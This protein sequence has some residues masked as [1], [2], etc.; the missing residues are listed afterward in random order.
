MLEANTAYGMCMHAA[1]CSPVCALAFLG[2]VCAPFVYW[3]GRPLTCARGP[4]CAAPGSCGAR[5]DP[6]SPL[7]PL[8]AAPGSCGS[9]S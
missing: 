1:Q 2:L 5:A 3:V 9:P 4:L 7:P 8:C 6:M